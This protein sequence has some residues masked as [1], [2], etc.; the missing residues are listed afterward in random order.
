MKT[1]EV[2]K[3][4]DI[5]IRYFCDVMRYLEIPQ[6]FIF[7]NKKKKNRPMVPTND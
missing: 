5:E 6:S 4:M 3:T 7:L 1:L 2:V